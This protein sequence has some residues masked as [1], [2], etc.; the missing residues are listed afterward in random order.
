MVRAGYVADEMFNAL[1]GSRRLLFYDPDNGRH[2]D[3]FIG[4]FSMC[5]DIPMT[6]PSAACH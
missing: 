2:L 4:E 1:R 6:M 5:H 3:V